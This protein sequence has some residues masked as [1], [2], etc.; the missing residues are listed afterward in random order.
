MCYYTL[1][2][3]GILYEHIGVIRVLV[4]GKMFEEFDL[5]KKLAPMKWECPTTTM[6][7]AER[8]EYFWRWKRYVQRT[9]AQLGFPVIMME[10]KEFEEY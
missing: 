4:E 10:D 2:L 6:S 1:Y 8:R 7:R 5:A 9:R 3:G